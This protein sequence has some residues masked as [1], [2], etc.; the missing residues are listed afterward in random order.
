M[1]DFASNKDELKM[2]IREVLEEVGARPRE[3]MKAKY[4]PRELALRWGYNEPQTIIRWI[5]K[6]KL[7]ATFDEYSKRWE[8]HADEVKRMDAELG[9]CAKSR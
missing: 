5:R 8:V 2:I 4:S 6:N 3:S 1:V 7:T 9:Y